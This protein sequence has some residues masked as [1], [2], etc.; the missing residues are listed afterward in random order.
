MKEICESL[1]LSKHAVYNY[2]GILKRVQ[3]ITFNPESHTHHYEAVPDAEIRF[4]GKTLSVKDLLVA[5][6]EIE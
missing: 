2:I 4:P 5:L 6:Q 3:L 1:F